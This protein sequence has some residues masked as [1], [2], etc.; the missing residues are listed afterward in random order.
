MREKA[1]KILYFLPSIQHVAYSKILSSHLSI[2]KRN[3]HTKITQRK[4]YFC[5]PFSLRTCRISV[6][7]H[8]SYVTHVSRP[9]V[10]FHSLSHPPFSRCES[11]KRRRVALRRKLTPKAGVSVSGPS[12]GKLVRSRD[13]CHRDVFPEKNHLFGLGGKRELDLAE[14]DAR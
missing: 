13:G 5:F 2:Q 10:F 4:Q 11:T 14:G 1:D 3:W 6:H 7:L 8:N 9:S 12:Q